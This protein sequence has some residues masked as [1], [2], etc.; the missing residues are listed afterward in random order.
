VTGGFL[1]R[2]KCNVGLLCELGSSLYLFELNFFGDPLNSAC[3]LHHAG[4]SE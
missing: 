3:C 4:G 1:Q 2:E